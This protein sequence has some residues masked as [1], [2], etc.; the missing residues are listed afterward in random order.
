MRRLMKC[1]G[2]LLRNATEVGEWLL[3]LSHDEP[4]KEFGPPWASNRKFRIIQGSKVRV[5]H[6]FSVGPANDV[7]WHYGGHLVGG[8]DE[9][10]VTVRFI[11]EVVQDD[12]SAAI[13]LSDG[14]KLMGTLHEL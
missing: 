2:R 6:D 7:C 14:Q 4:D 8:I 3:L 5:I 12:R 10:V 9:L 13:E 1:G 11:L